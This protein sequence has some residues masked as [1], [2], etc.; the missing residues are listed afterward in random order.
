MFIVIEHFDGEVNA[1][2]CQDKKAAIVKK[3]ELVC[4]LKENYNYNIEVDEPELFEAEIN[5]M[6]FTIDIRDMEVFELKNAEDLPILK[7]VLDS[8]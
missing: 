3:H 7:D 6:I 4:N 5:D 8:V 1:Y 2:P